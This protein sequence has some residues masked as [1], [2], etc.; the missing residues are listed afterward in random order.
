MLVEQNLA[1]LIFL[2]VCCC[3]RTPPCRGGRCSTASSLQISAS[4]R[5]RTALGQ[6]QKP[7]R[8]ASAVTPSS[9][10]LSSDSWC[11][12]SQAGSRSECPRS[13]YLSISSAYR[14]GGRGVPSWKAAYTV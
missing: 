7:D 10:H 6:V 13:R 5:A 2:S 11:L 1:S 3:S 8:S 9:R 14:S 4:V 12:H